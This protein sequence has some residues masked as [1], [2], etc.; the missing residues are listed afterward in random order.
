MDCIFNDY[1]YEKMYAYSPVEECNHFSK[2][3]FLIINVNSIPNGHTLLRS[4]VLSNQDEINNKNALGLTALHLAVRNSNIY[5]LGTVNLLLENGADVNSIDEYGWTALMMASKYSNTTSSLETIRLLLEKGADINLINEYGSTALMMAAQYSNTTSSLETVSLL[6]ERGADVNLADIG[7]STAL[8]LVAQKS[9]TDSSKEIVRLLDKG[10]NLKLTIKQR[11]PGWPGL[12][13]LMMAARYSNT[14]SG[15]ETVKLLLEK[16]ADVNLANRD[17]WTALMM[18][19]RYSNTDSD[20]ETVK[21]LLAKE[22]NINI[23]NQNKDTALILAAENSNIETVKLLLE[24]GA[25]ANVI[26]KENKTFFDY[27]PKKYLLDCLKIIDQIE[28]HKLRMKELFVPIHEI[29]VLYP[30]PDSFI[31]KIM[32]IKFRSSNSTLFEE[33]KTDNPDL[34]AYFGINDKASLEWKIT[35]SLKYIDR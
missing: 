30:W 15:L 33:L 25:D 5:S 8:M 11:W 1:D 7:G 31:V 14:D 29:G 4:Y 23:S 2:L 22:T 21:L 16:G 32:G 24:N 10:A 3:M 26:N 6:L 27:I 20:L 34:L 28:L 9:N 35:D 12:E 18:A 13:I 19:A 17:G